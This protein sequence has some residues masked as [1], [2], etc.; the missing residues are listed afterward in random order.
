MPLLTLPSLPNSLWPEAKT[1]N[2]SA[3]RDTFGMQ[4]ITLFHFFFL[5]TKECRPQD[6][7]RE[8]SVPLNSRDSSWPR[9]VLLLY[10]IG[11]I[12]LHITTSQQGISSQFYKLGQP[13][14]SMFQFLTLR[15][16]GS[17]SRLTESFQSILFLSSSL[18]YVSRSL[19]RY[20]QFWSILNPLWCTSQRNATSF[21]QTHKS[22]ENVKPI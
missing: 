18:C 5:P 8:S 15:V 12:F 14:F 11:C 9:R 20:L 13:L 1:S 22:T 19:G 4:T 21:I 3:F 7:P 17:S 10:L 2:T 16:L 6:N